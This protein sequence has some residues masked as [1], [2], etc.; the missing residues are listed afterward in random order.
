MQELI[1]SKTH[2]S[3][4]HNPDLM[5]ESNWAYLASMEVATDIHEDVNLFGAQTQT[6]ASNIFSNQLERKQS[7]Q[8][9]G[10]GGPRGTQAEKSGKESS[11]NK[12]AMERLQ[13]I[14]DP[15]DPRFDKL[16]TESIAVWQKRVNELCDS[17]NMGVDRFYVR[18]T[19]TYNQICNS[20][21]FCREEFCPTANLKELT[22]CQ[23]KNAQKPWNFSSLPGLNLKDSSSLGENPE[24]LAKLS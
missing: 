12:D 13:G 5:A 20:N 21:N 8:A 3:M 4:V 11:A 15:E 7:I 23:V 18:K 24:H 22:P 6:S 17:M 14:I 2:E 19:N 1:V 16:K 10:K 9:S